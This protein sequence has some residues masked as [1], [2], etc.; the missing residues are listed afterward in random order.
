VITLD[1]DTPAML[2]APVAEVESL[3]TARLVARQ[4]AALDGPG[5]TLAR[6]RP[7]PVAVAGLTSA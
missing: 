3:R 7:A 5:G 6:P 2:M 1:Y 4:G